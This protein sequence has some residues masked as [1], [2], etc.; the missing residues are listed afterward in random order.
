MLSRERDRSSRETHQRAVTDLAGG[1]RRPVLLRGRLVAHLAGAQAAVVE[2][3]AID[4]PFQQNQVQEEGERVM[5]DIRVCERVAGGLCR[6][7]GVKP[8]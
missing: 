6:G 8:D 5:L 2:K 4:I 1:A 3:V 7:R